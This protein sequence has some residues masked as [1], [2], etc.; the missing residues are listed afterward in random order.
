MVLEGVR[1][2][3]RRH[4]AV[5]AG[6]GVVVEG[7]GLRRVLSLSALEA[8][9]NRGTRFEE[10]PGRPRSRSMEGCPLRVSKPVFPAARARKPALRAADSTH[11]RER[12]VRRAKVERRGSTAAHVPHALHGPC[13]PWKPSR[14]RACSLARSRRAPRARRPRPPV[15]P[16]SAGST[17]AAS[18]QA[19]AMRSV[20]GGAGG[21]SGDYPTCQGDHCRGCAKATAGPRSTAAAITPTLRARRK[22]MIREKEKSGLLARFLRLQHCRASLMRPG[23]PRLPR[24]P[25]STGGCGPACRPRAP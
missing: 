21:A 11:S 10:R 14:T 17:A 22:Q 6:G 13:A 12:R 19:P 4:A 18:R 15:D 24:P 5:R 1:A 8:R 23:R 2:T 3:M 9:A 20:D 25:S 16:A 7:H